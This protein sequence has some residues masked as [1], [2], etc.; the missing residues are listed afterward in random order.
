MCTRG[1]MQ[2]GAIWRPEVQAF[3]RALAGPDAD[4]GFF[5]KIST[6]SLQAIDLPGPLSAS[7]CLMVRDWRRW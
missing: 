2:A 7:F 1:Q 6:V 3:D 5:L 4:K